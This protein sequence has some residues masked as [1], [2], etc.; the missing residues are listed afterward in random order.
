M[1][2]LHTLCAVPLLAVVATVARGQV[3]RGT[4][5]AELTGLPVGQAVVQLVDSS[6]T[7]R[8]G[9]FSDDSGHFA[10]RAPGD[11]RYILRAERIGFRPSPDI[12]LVLG[13]GE[14]VERTVIMQPV[15][16]PL[17]EVLTVGKGRCSKRDDAG[18][19]A[20][21]WVAARASLQAATV[22]Q[23]QRMLQFELVRYDRMKSL[24][25]K[26]LSEQRATQ[27]EASDNPITSLHADTLARYGY[28]RSEAAD[29]M[30]YYAPDARVLLSE[31]FARDHC[32][33]LRAA[34]ADHPG[35]LGLYFEPVRLGQLIDVKGVLWLDD[36]TSELRTL[37]YQY[38]SRRV[39]VPDDRFGGRLEFE[40]LDN[41]AVIVRRWQ[42][43]VPVYSTQDV[44][45]ARAR[46]STYRPRVVGVAEMGGEVRTAVV[47]R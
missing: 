1:R 18:A 24:D 42:M 15:P 10:I 27:V 47:S 9:A 31:R 37:E 4:V 7:K 13:V 26:T 30:S 22:A 20:D 2:V 38:A 36:S 14:A 43:R 46:R 35:M 28:R 19:I 11:G 33:A 32:F 6:G 25:G 17:G 34:D 8:L 23:E 45:F 12:A 39:D 40:R 16:S 3:V 41:G 44:Y 5:V 21:V 29:T